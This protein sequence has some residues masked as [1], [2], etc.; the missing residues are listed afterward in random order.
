MTQRILS[1]V[2]VLFFAYLTIICVRYLL[3]DLGVATATPGVHTGG[4]VQIL[5][6]IFCAIVCVGW[7]AAFVGFWLASKK[8]S[9]SSGPLPRRRVG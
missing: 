4:P 1:A 2:M 9:T 6:D 3:D 5:L 8:S 7:I